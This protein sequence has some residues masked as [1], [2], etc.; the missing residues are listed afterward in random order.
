MLEDQD[1][2]QLTLNLKRIFS[3]PLTKLTFKEI[4]RSIF[5]TVREDKDKANQV[6]ESLLNGIPSQ[7]NQPD[8]PFN[9]FIEEY[10][11]PTRLAR[12]VLEKGEFISFLSSDLVN[13]PHPLFINQLRR[14]D[15]E[16]FQFLTEPEGIIHLL[17]HFLGRIEELHRLDK[18]KTFIKAHSPELRLIKDKLDK[19]LS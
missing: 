6:L 13:P 18:S 4:Q 11:L 16:E 1:L 17:K 9:Q 3:F 2:R 5:T 14:M 15:G 7:A 19:L 10:T 12:D 8:S